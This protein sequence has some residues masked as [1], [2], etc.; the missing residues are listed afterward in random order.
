M[1][2]EKEK[3]MNITYKPWDGTTPESPHRYD[4]ST[5]THPLFISSEGSIYYRSNDGELCIWCARVRLK[6]HLQRLYQIGVIKE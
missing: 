2:G 6:Y 1:A 4:V 5:S 3:D